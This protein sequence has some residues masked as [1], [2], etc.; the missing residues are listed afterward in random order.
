MAH[1]RL[2]KQIPIRATEGTK[3]VKPQSRW[4]DAMRELIKARDISDDDFRE[5][6]GDWMQWKHSEYEGGVNG[7]DGLT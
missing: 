3:R 1:D 4:V 7:D 5:L 2:V 6:I